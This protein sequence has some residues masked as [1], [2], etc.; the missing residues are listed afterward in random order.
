MVKPFLKQFP[1]AI[2]RAGLAASSQRD[3]LLWVVR[4]AEELL[5]C[6]RQGGGLVCSQTPPFFSRWRPPHSCKDC[7]HGARPSGDSRHTNRLAEAC[8]VT[9]DQRQKSPLQPD[10]QG[11]KYL[12]LEFECHSVREPLKLCNKAQWNPRGINTK[13]TSEKKF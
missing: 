5:L 8:G 13:S 2:F 3:P 4:K 9:E 1:E 12:D 6:S 7:T 10:S 11:C